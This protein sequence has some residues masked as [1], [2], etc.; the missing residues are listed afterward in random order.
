LA[1]SEVTRVREHTVEDVMTR[2]VIAAP[3]ETPF[4]ELVRLMQ[5]HRVSGVPVVDGG[6]KLFGIVTEADL[7]I[8]EEEQVEQRGRGRSLLEWFVHPKRLAAAQARSEDLRVRDVMTPEV[9]TATPEMRVRDAVKVLLDAGVKRL[10][11]VDGDGRVVGIASRRDLLKPFLRSAEDINEEIVQE[12]VL[13]AMWLDPAAIGVEV[14][15]GVVTLEGQ[16]DRKSTKQIL[17]EMV[18]RVDGVVGVEDRVTYEQDDR[19][20]PPA[21]LHEELAWG[22][23]WVRRE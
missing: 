19:E 9:V 2:E 7:L 23:N 8:A 10:P 18:R 20:V 16:V 1:W 12:V 6:G 4:T 17:A 11:V 15:R 14:N 21:P 3:Q 13:R 22:E 5:E